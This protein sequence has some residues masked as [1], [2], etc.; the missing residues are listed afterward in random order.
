MIHLQIGD[1]C[2]DIIGGGRHCKGVEWLKFPSVESQSMKF[3]V[4]SSIVIFI[5]SIRNTQYQCTEN[6]IEEILLLFWRFFL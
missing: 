1:T 2:G 5:L 3:N 4:D 6:K